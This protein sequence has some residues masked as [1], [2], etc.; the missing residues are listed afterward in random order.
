MVTID[1]SF[2]IIPTCNLNN[3]HSNLL[4]CCVT[5]LLNV[6]LLYSEHRLRTRE[7]VE[8]RKYLGLYFIIIYNVYKSVQ[9]KYEL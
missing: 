6:V 9:T 8:T 7:S 3:I 5:K 1:E 2:N 4:L